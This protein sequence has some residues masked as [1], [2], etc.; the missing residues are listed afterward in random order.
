MRT[1]EQIA[2]SVLQSM[3]SFEPTVCIVGNVT[4]LEVTRLLTDA[5]TACPACG[6]EPWVDIDCRVCLVMSALEEQP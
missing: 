3:I 6:A 1:K 2:T 5:F 4:A